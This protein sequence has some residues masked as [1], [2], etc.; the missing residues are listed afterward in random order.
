M[1]VPGAREAS[2]CPLPWDW[3][4]GAPSGQGMDGT[5]VEGQAWVLALLTP[6]G[7]VGPTRDLAMFHSALREKPWAGP[8]AQEKRVGRSCGSLRAGNAQHK[9]S[10]SALWGR[11][12]ASQLTV[13]GPGAACLHRPIG[14]ATGRAI[15]PQDQRW[16]TDLWVG[17]EVSG[18][19]TA[20][21]L[22]PEC[23][24][25]PRHLSGRYRTVGQGQA[26]HMKTEHLQG[27]GV[28]DPSTPLSGHD[29]FCN[30][31]PAWLLR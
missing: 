27:Q 30:H 4:V 24:A 7:T 13:P 17:G 6:R 22:G 9:V 8:G 28:G 1:E 31:L 23:R 15:R 12:E 11:R 21:R 16:L 10:H 5:A 19:L 20:W 2:I 14:Q 29:Q 3:A 18:M 26:L 25:E